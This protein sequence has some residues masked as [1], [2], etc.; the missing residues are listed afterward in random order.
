[1]NAENHNDTTVQ[2]LVIGV[3][4]ERD[5]AVIRTLPGNNRCNEPTTC[6]IYHALGQA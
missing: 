5:D 4:E 2:V 6:Y 3:N 1:M